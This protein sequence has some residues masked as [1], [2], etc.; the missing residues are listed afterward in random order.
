MCGAARWL[1]NGQG[2]THKDWTLT[3]E[4]AYEIDR[5]GE[6]ARFQPFKALP[7]RKLLFHGSRLR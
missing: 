7:N 5:T 3:L 4:H 6:E 2:P 1:Q